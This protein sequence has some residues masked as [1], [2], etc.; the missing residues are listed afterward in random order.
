LLFIVTG[1]HYYALLMGTVLTT[2]FGTSA[3]FVSP[4]FVY[5]LGRSLTRGCTLIDAT[6][7]GTFEVAVL[8][9]FATLL[10]GYSSPISGLTNLGMLMIAQIGARLTGGGLP[11][12]GG[13]ALTSSGVVL[14]YLGMVCYFAIGSR[15]P[16]E[17]INIIYSLV[18]PMVGTLLAVFWTLG[19]LQLANAALIV[20]TLPT[21]LLVE[22]VWWSARGK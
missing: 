15:Q 16:G 17:K 14:F 9:F 8:L 7:F 4:Y 6:I 5:R 19:V 10:S 20:L 12:L 11:N 1:D 13:D 3:I 21:I 18:L 22:V 2:W